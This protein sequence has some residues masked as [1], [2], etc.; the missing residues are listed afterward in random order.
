MTSRRLRIRA[1]LIILFLLIGGTVTNIAVAWGFSRYTNSMDGKVR[2][3][4]VK[5]SSNEI[6][7][8]LLFHNSGVD[9]VEFDAVPSAPNFVSASESKVIPKWVD[10]THSPVSN[11][12]NLHIFR[13][14][15]WPTLALQCELVDLPRKR[16]RSEE[17]EE[18]SPFQILGGI[19]TEKQPYQ[20]QPPLLLFQQI[21]PIHPIWPNF[22]LNTIFYAAIL[23][24][25]FFAPGVLRR[26]LRIKR[27]QCPACAY[28][29]GTNKLCT[30]CGKPV[31][32]R[33]V[34]SI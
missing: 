21:L 22:A 18:S 6:S 1:I 13:A 32:A 23:W 25:L 3:E 14:S 26:R 10:L 12:N 2:H 5:H 34:D 33:S 17:K 8:I 29:I 15:G 4:W 16:D 11:E 30:E 24:L 7:A 31:T 19:E 9:A 28:P 20:G 27:H